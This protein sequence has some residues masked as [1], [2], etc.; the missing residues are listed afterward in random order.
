MHKGQ[1]AD[2]RHSSAHF[3]KV[4]IALKNQYEH[5]LRLFRRS[6]NLSIPYMLVL[7]LSVALVILCFY[8]QLRYNYTADTLRLLVF[9]VILFVVFFIYISYELTVKLHDHNMTEYLQTYG[10]GLWKTYAAI[11]LCLLTLIMIPALILSA[12]TIFLYFFIDARY[13]PFLLHLLKLSLLYFILAFF[14]G[15]ML[16]TAMAAVFKARRLAVYSLTLLF[17][18]L[19]TAAP[20]SVFRV[21]Y[22]LFNAYGVEKILYDVKDF[23]TI[24]PLE[25]GSSFEVVPLYGFPMEPHRWLLAFFWLLFPLTLIYYECLTVGKKKKAILAVSSLLVVLTVGLFSWRG[26]TLIMDMRT[27]SFV[28]GDYMHYTEMNHSPVALPDNP[29]EFSITE[30]KMVLTVSNQLHAAVELTIDALNLENYDFTLY[31][32]Y[33]LKSVSSADGQPVPFEREGDYITVSPPSGARR[34]LFQYAGRSPKYFANRQAIALPG[35][36][37][38]YPKAGRQEIWSQ[39]N[40]SYVIDLPSTDSEYTVTI[41]SNLPV[42]SN[43]PGVPGNHNSFQGKSNG[44]T[45]LAGMYSRVAD[46]LYAEPMREDA[47]VSKNALIKAV[48]EAEARIVEACERLQRSPAPF[49]IGDKKIFQVPRAFSLNSQ[50][51]RAVVMNDHITTTGIYDGADFAME[52]MQAHFSQQVGTIFSSSYLSCLFDS[53]SKD[54]PLVTVPMD[55]VSLLEDLEEFLYLD[56]RVNSMTQEKFQALTEP[57]KTRYLK[58][59]QRHAEMYI[60]IHQK[61]AVYLFYRSPRKEENLRAYFNFFTS[62]SKEHY[63]ALAEKLFREEIGYANR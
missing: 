57:E 28:L 3:R 6:K 43:L 62:D 15:G 53:L 21:P 50:T 36:F 4:E 25:L 39:A 48:R 29:K 30:Y 31:H 20:M 61:I 9:P 45:L 24:V 22:L 27:T 12:F 49:L 33:R 60:S 59:E 32:G 47:L 51:E 7:F 54:N 38:Y 26:S 17:L 58:A 37:A 16:G 56:S 44:L 42:Y 13:I 10:R 18:F 35:Y 5:I 63:L 41:Y 8:I 52:I 1:S 46:N 2:Y 14:A 11:L 23:V 19:N 40:N 34:L 55:P